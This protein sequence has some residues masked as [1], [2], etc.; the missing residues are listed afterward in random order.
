[1]QSNT[2]QRERG[3]N[4]EI[5]GRIAGSSGNDRDFA[6]H[7]SKNGQARKDQGGPRRSA[8][9]HPGH[10]T[11]EAREAGRDVRDRKEAGL[12]SHSP[13]PQR[14]SWFEVEQ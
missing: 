11:G 4:D 8:A 2:K 6:L 9:A 7:F 10:R 5:N 14:S 12:T 1:M 13:N 3:G